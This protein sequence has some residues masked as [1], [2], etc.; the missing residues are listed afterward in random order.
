MDIGLTHYLIVAGLLFSIG[1][2]GLLTSRHLIRI[3]M[4][5]ELMLNA[6]NINFVAINNAVNPDHLAGQLFAIFILTISAAEAAIG[7]AIV[8][9]L[10]RA[11][12]TVDVESFEQLKG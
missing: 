6:V 3:L 10:F 5:V 4:S 1:L 8:I 2:L 11:R 12:S 7:L 9:A